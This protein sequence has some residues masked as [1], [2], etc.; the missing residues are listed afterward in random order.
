[1]GSD[2]NYSRI[3]VRFAFSPLLATWDKLAEQKNTPW[4]SVK[5]DSTKAFRCVAFIANCTK[6][7]V[8]YLAYAISTLVMGLFSIVSLPIRSLMKQVSPIPIPNQ[9]NNI[10]PLIPRGITVHPKQKAEFHNLLNSQIFS[11]YV[12]KLKDFVAKQIDDKLTLKAGHSQATQIPEHPF[13]K[14]TLKLIQVIANAEVTTEKTRNQR[15]HQDF[16]VKLRALVEAKR[17]ISSSETHPGVIHS[18]E[19]I[20]KLCEFIYV[21][22]N[23]MPEFTQ[24]VEGL[25]ST[26]ANDELE[27]FP[28]DKMPHWLKKWHG[29]LNPM[30]HG[31]NFVPKLHDAHL[32]G[33][34]PTVLYHYPL[35]GRN[36]KIIRTPTI[37]EDIHSNKK[38]DPHSAQ[39][40]KEFEGFLDSYRKQNKTHLYVNLMQREGHGSEQIRSRAVEGLVAKYPDN[41]RVISLAVN[42][43]FHRQITPSYDAPSMPYADFK[44][45]FIHE[46]FVK[47]PGAYCWPAA[48]P[49]DWPQK[50]EKI[51]D[52]VHA[53]NFNSRNELLIQ[54]RKD[55]IE[56]AYMEIIEA[57][58]E[59]LNP[60]SSNI[61]C[62]SCIDRGAA[63]LT[64]QF[65]KVCGKSGQPMGHAQRKQMAAI[66][67]APA[68]LAHNRLMMT[69][70]MER[71]HTTLQRMF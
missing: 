62:L 2:N 19:F 36:I 47:T 14:D 43:N 5:A 60:E 52:A 42:S 28:L 29:K 67:L 31:Y 32:F 33:D 24:F 53:R 58:M 50:C 23:L 11:T 55:F 3:D 4:V 22:T 65:I 61:S 26:E 7:A 69:E 10:I 6:K 16:V 21:G 18:I 41:F 66:A 54:E 13:H 34:V 71:L 57:A 68:I 63:L 15:F 64:E 30:F 27:Q 25:L 51:L 46:M 12:H 9:I 49:K 20:E 8:I 59:V 38:G 45:H 70:R 39:A 17:T 44:N 40:V 56:V 35:A 48:L 1:M 37:V